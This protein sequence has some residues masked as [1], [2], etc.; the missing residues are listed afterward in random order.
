VSGFFD[1]LGEQRSA[2][3]T[4]V[5]C[6]AAGAYQSVARA[7]A[8]NATICLDPFHVITWANEA[9]DAFYRST[10]PLPTLDDV[11]GWKSGQR[12]RPNWQRLRV[13]LRTGGE[14]LDDRQ[15]ALITAVRRHSRRLWRAWQLKEELRE[16]SHGTDPAAARAHLNSWITAAL[17]SR[18][19]HMQTL[20]RRLRKH[21]D[22]VIAAVELGLSNSRLEGINTKIRVI[23]RRGYGH[24]NPDTLTAMIYLCLG[25]INIPLPTHKREERDTCSKMGDAPGLGYAA[26]AGRPECPRHATRGA[27]RAGDEHR[28]RCVRELRT[29]WLDPP[30]GP[31][32]PV[33]RQA[34]SCPDRRQAHR[35]PIGL[36]ARDGRPAA[37]QV[38]RPAECGCGPRTL[39]GDDS[40][41]TAARTPRGR[42][43]G[44]RRQSSTREGMMQRRRSRLCP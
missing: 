44:Y 18:I 23:Q 15:H 29:G 37:S 43:A 4:A 9:L 27:R 7:R 35:P 14:R 39:S 19:G 8:V 20:A 2:A 36:A 42:G 13:A 26:L 5:T 6:D 22:A 30:G 33:V 31:V 1:A 16:L 11:A 28:C 21:L 24:R 41:D 34:R 40:H 25:G 17:R 32:R 38:V 12:R 3:L 10:P